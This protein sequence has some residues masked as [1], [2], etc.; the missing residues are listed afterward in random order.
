MISAWWLLA[1]FFT[2]VMFGLFIAALMAIQKR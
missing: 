1:A 2:G